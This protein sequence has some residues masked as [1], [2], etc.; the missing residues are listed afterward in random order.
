MVIVCLDTNALMM[1]IECDVRVFEGVES[2][3][4]DPEFVASAGVTARMQ[5]TSHVSQSYIGLTG[6]LAG[7]CYHCSYFSLLEQPTN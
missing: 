1:P 3:I 6:L 4:S 2:L 5:C 7:A